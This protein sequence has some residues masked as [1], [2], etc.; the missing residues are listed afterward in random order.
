MGI[1]GPNGAGKSTL[2]RVIAKIYK[3]ASGSV[4]VH[5]FTVPLLGVGVGFNG[6]LTARENIIQMGAILGI[7]SQ[8]ACFAG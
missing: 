8:A 7:D 2:L 6:E 1:V 3:P 4:T 5:G